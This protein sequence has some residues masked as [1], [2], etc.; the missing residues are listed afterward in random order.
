M[1]KFG[2]TEDDKCERCG[3]VETKT[4]Q[5]FECRYAKK[6]WTHYNKTMRAM[7]LAEVTVNSIEQAITPAKEGNYFS[8][9]LKSVVLKANIQ[10]TRPKHNVC[11]L[12]NAN[13][14]S[15]ARIEHKVSN[16]NKLQSNGKLKSLWYK[17]LLSYGKT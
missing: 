16:K 3:L 15:Q 6:M 14:C 12:I 4:H 17:L 2:M 7:G 1:K 10:I 11:S 8:E 9:T 5:L 13:F